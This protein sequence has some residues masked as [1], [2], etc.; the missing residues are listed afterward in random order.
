MRKLSKD[1][2]KYVGFQLADYV[3]EQ[4]GGGYVSSGLMRK[5]R[6]GI[7][8]ICVSTFGQEHILPIKRG[9]S[10]ILR[11][12]LQNRQ[13]GITSKLLKLFDSK[14][15][16]SANVISKIV[17]EIAHSNVSDEYKSEQNMIKRSWHEKLKA[18]SDSKNLEKA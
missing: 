6:S 1:L 4:A 5:I 13:M 17:D 7:E 9:S 2:M 3:N 11:T 16:S 14:N 18:E 10:K 12:C 8:N 15:T